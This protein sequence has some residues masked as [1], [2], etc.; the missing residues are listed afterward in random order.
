ME[1][2]LSLANEVANL[3]E[4]YALQQISTDPLQDFSKNLSAPPH[5][6]AVSARRLLESN[7]RTLA[8]RLNVEI[9]AATLGQQIEELVQ[10]LTTDTRVDRTMADKFA[11]YSK[12][13][14][15][16]GDNAA[17][18]ETFKVDGYDAEVLV[19]AVM[20]LCRCSIALFRAIMDEPTKVVAARWPR[21]VQ[22]H[23]DATTMR[24][25]RDNSTKT[26]WI[27]NVPLEWTAEDLRELLPRQVQCLGC[28]VKSNNKT[29]NVNDNQYKVRLSR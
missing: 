20:Q 28:S 19:L 29:W 15:P 10:H 27:G 23:R 1:R 11:L 22:P 8:R 25:A 17:H 14:K 24:V 12:L 13:I 3:R 18:A 16:L 9:R 4:E 21:A 2:Q 5:A 26:L 7:F 6:I